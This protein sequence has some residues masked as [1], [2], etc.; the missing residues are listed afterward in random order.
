[1]KLRN[2]IFPIIICF[3]ITAEAGDPKLPVTEIMGKNY[4]YY[5]A[6]KGESLYGIAKKFGW[7]VDVL[8]NL[9][10]ETSKD[11]KKGSRLYYPAKNVSATEESSTET[12]TKAEFEIEPIRHTVKKGETVYSIAK[13]YNLSLETIYKEYPSSK[14]GVKTGEMMVFPQNLK[15]GYY[16][17]TAKDD[18]TLLSVAQ[19]FNTSVEDLLKDNPGVSEK[20]IK[21]GETVRV[22]VDSNNLKIKKT[23]VEEERL[24]KIDNYKVEKEDTWTTIA[25]KTGVEEEVLK[26]VNNTENEL[27]ENT[28]LAVPVVETVEVEKEVDFEDVRELTSEGIQEIYD[29]IHGVSPEKEMLNQVR[30]ALILD[31]PTSKKDI[32][33]T[34]GFLIGLSDFTDSPYSIDLEVMDGRVAPNTLTDN[35]EGYEPNL[36]LATADR[37]FPAFLADFGNTNNIQIVNVFDLKNDLY[38]DNASMV[39]LLPPSSYLYEHLATRI[40]NDNSR[41]SLIMVG[42]TDENDGMATELMENYGKD[43]KNLSIEELSLYEPDIMESLIVY[44]YPTKKEEIGD[45]IQAVGNIRENFPAADIKIMGRSNWV[46][47]VDELG[48]QFHE[49]EVTIPSRVWLDENSKEW[50]TFCEKY[51]EMFTG[52]PVRSFPNF[53]ASGYDMAN[54][55]IPVV[56]QNGGD[57]NGG[58]NPGNNSLLQ[59][60]IDLKRVNNWGGFINTTGY[61]V[62]FGP[63]GE[64]EK[65]TV[66]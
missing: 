41:R 17:Y 62:K 43:V 64:I 9:N 34:R 8:R 28:V 10:P 20:K 15:D 35:L 36:I 39:Q 47:L 14:T 57:F 52:T 18:D 46:T 50:E 58:L 25:E 51:E 19:K 55:F 53:A 31:D 44:A 59:G 32:D 61:L 37:A 21:S 29:S 12:N 26:E 54:Y 30:V 48:D 24:A 60:E 45:F 66:K 13:Q 4:Y 63:E 27:K 16:Y 42:E 33:F 65:I 23:V 1:M 5:E 7:N 38:E 2:I 11:V 49:I 40:K 56:A 22:K 6:K 3:F